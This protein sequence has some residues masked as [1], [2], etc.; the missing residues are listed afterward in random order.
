MDGENNGEPY[1]NGW[2]RGKTPLFSETSI[3]YLHI[4]P[5][6]LHRFQKVILQLHRFRPGDQ[7]CQALRNVRD[8]AP[9][10]AL[11]STW[12]SRWKLGSVGYNP[13]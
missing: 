4:F 2:F 3:F 1:E 5:E 12:M 7:C 11:V 9:L 10:G 13:T 8:D 6:D